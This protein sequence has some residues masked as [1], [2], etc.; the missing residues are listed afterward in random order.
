MVVAP[1]LVAASLAAQQPKPAGAPAPPPPAARAAAPK[2]VVE[3]LG[4][5]GTT[6]VSMDTWAG[7]P[8]SD[9][10]TLAYGGMGRLLMPLGTTTKIGVEAGYRYLFWWTYAPSGYN[11]TY[12]V[13]AT[14]VAGF[15]RVPLGT[16]ITVDVGAAAHFF[17]N[18]G[19]HVGALGTK[20]LGDDLEGVLGGLEHLRVGAE[21][22]AR[23][24]PAA[25]RSDFLHR[26]GRLAAVVLLRPDAAVAG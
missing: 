6:V 17:N 18:A 20:A 24:S 13:T 16:T 11:Y 12:A 4:S 26:G 25:L 21:G 22:R 1:L 7:S 5:I 23:A 19:T 3:V 15:V 2:Y 9:W 8:A 14:H 10:S